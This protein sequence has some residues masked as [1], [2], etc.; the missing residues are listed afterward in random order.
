VRPC[1]CALAVALAR[2]VHLCI[3]EPLAKGTLLFR[4]TCRS[5]ALVVDPHSELGVILFEI[6]PTQYSLVED[7]ISLTLTLS[8]LDVLGE[9]SFLIVVFVVIVVVLVVISDSGFMFIFS[10]P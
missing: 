7:D 9:V 8:I 4:A 6:S 2:T 1:E 5:E 3:L 10:A